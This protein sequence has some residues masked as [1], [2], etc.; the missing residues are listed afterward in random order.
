MRKYILLALMLVIGISLF[1]QNR[2]VKFAKSL[3][4]PGI[5]QISD[6][7]SYG[8]AMLASEAVIIGSMIFLNNEEKLRYQEAYDYALKYANIAPGKYPETYLRDLGRYNSGGFDADGY[9]SRIL[10]DALNLYPHD[11]EQ[12]QAYINQNAYPEEMFWAWDSPANRARYGSIRKSAHNLRDYGKLAIGVLL[13]NHLVSGIDVLRY[14]GQEN[15]PQLS[16]G[17]KDNN[18]I[19]NLSI[20]F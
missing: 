12:Q 2:G 8:Y 1:A 6:G 10:K 13:V 19:L 17:I 14:S 4:I 3:A 15:R 9:N 20:K 16:L 5:S 11:P 7:K 18:P